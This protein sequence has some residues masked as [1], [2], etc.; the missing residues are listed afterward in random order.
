MSPDQEESI[1]KRFPR[2][3]KEFEKTG[4]DMTFKN[5]HEWLEEKGVGNR[6]YAI[7]MAKLSKEL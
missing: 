5:L 2:Q 7:G 6:Y 1:R 4:K 3:L